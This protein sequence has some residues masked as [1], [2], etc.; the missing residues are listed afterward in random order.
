[1]ST[2]DDPAATARRLLD[3]IMYMTLATADEAG[4]P[5]ASPVWYA[6]ASPTELI[7]VSDP[8][9][10]HSRNL[11]AR[12]EIGIVIFDSTVP[13]GGAEAVYIDAVAAPVEDADLEPA[14]DSYSRRSKEVGGV[15]WTSADVRA[16]ARLR[17]YRA[18]VTAMSVLDEGDRRIPVEL[19]TKERR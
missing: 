5:W 11:A 4:R 7:W 18:R 19:D 6:A 15:G 14:I 10:R 9:G 3:S 8:S 2:T 12:P 13:I 1:M 17:L 16:P